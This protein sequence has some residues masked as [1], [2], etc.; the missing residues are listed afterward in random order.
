MSQD[1]QCEAWYERQCHY[2]SVTEPQTFLNT[3]D[4]LLLDPGPEGQR[5]SST[6]HCTDDFY[7]SVSQPSTFTD[8]DTGNN[9]VTF[10]VSNYYVVL[11]I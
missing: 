11:L 4:C 8:S 2:V 1:P 7:V 10:L 6:D 9:R 3:E 5:I